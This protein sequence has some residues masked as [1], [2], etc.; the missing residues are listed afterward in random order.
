M[1]GGKYTLGRKD[2][3]EIGLSY[4]KLEEAGTGGIW[5]L[6]TLCDESVPPLHCKKLAW[7]CVI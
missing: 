6:A 5:P 1:N 4:L 3:P 7:A 2:I